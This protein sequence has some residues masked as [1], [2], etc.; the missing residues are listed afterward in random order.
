LGIDGL[1]ERQILES[2]G[3]TT[4]SRKENVSLWLEVSDMDDTSVL[5]KAETRSALSPKER[6]RLSVLAA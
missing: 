6:L 2:T 1:L 3:Q 4:R 5:L